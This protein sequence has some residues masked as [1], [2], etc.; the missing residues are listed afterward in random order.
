VIK[1]AYPTARRG[2]KTLQKTPRGSSVTTRKAL[3]AVGLTSFKGVAL[4]PPT[5]SMPGRQR[6]TL[7][8]MGDTNG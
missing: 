2:F 3:E 5:L 7:G 8:F 4:W 6:D 1:R